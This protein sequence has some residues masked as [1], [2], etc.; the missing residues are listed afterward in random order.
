MQS[1]AEEISKNKE[2]YVQNNASALNPQQISDKQTIYKKKVRFQSILFL[3]ML[4]RTPEGSP[5]TC[6]LQYPE[7]PAPVFSL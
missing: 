1:V 5:P 3:V 6:R 7:D 4:P 2:N